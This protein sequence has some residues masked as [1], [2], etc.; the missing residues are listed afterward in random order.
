[1]EQQH[2]TL[3][4]TF[5]YKLLPTLEQARALAT[6]VWRCRA[7]YNAAL[8]PRKTWWER[9]QGVSA[10]YDQQKAELPGLKAACPEYA[11]VHSQVLQDVLLRLDRTFRAFSR[12][13]SAGETAGYPRFQGHSRYNSFTSPQ[14]GNGA[15][16]DGGVLS[17]SKIGCL[18][19]R[20]RRPL[21]GTP[22]T[23]AVRREADGWYA[24]ISCAQVPSLRRSPQR[25]ARRG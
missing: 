2:G 12:R 9:G 23:V 15:A 18:L 21:E 13:V 19:I 6:V 1:M 24:C 25:D 14:D 8:E 22:K 5:K 17:L 16:L 3:R 10:T 20:L 4:K 11:A 7:R